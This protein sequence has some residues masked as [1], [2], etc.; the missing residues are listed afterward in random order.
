MVGE[1]G[2]AQEYPNK[3]G[4]LIE[5][6]HPIEIVSKIETEFEFIRQ[7]YPRHDKR[8]SFIPLSF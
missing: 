1:N 7:S 4:M 5:T 6:V 2:A 8:P 3:L